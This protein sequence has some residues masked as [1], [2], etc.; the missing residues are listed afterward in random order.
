MKEFTA[1]VFLGIILHYSGQ[2]YLEEQFKS[3]HSG[4]LTSPHKE[5]CY[6]MGAN[7]SCQNCIGQQSKV[8]PRCEKS[9]VEVYNETIIW[10]SKINNFQVIFLN[11]WH[12]S[13]NKSDAISTVIDTLTLSIFPNIAAFL[14]YISIPLSCFRNNAVGDPNFLSR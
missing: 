14:T 4:G 2:L 7:I 8:K 1:D 12:F 6:R 3:K 10:Y 13:S 5:R 11:I 9:Q